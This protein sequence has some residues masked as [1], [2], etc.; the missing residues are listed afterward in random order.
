MDA[1]DAY[2]TSFETDV[3]APSKAAVN[4]L[5]PIME[6]FD[7]YKGVGNAVTLTLDAGDGYYADTPDEEAI[8]TA[9][10]AVDGLS[11]TAAVMYDFIG[12]N[13][14]EF[15]FAVQLQNVYT[16]ETITPSWRLPSIPV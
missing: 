9:L 16:A 3:I 7:A 12:R 8:R 6:K 11:D 2:A 1:F 15:K 14:S 13:I 10:D 4:I 5:L